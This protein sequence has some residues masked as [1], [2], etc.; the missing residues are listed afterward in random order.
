[1]SEA[2]GPTKPDDPRYLGSSRTYHRHRSGEALWRVLAIGVALAFL[3]IYLVSAG[4]RIGYPFELEWMEGGMVDHVARLVAAQ[5]IYTPPTLTFVPYACT[6]LYFLLSAAVTK[7]LG[8]GFLSLRTVSAAAS[9]GLF[10]LIGLIVRRHTN[11]WTGAILAVGLYAATFRA[12]GFSFDLAR[13]DS[14]FLFLLIAAA[15]LIGYQN[16]L[17]ARLLASVVIFLAFL[18]KQGTLV[19]LPLLALASFLQIRGKTLQWLLPALALITIG[20]MTLDTY[21]T[22]VGSPTM[23]S[24]CHAPARF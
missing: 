14:L 5:P 22:M 7:I 13:V 24:T 20:T 2:I 18:T 23:F 9:I 10:V 3:G 12:S 17:G 16:S 4:F 19:F 15:F 6:P 11:G 1:M 21:S 8:L